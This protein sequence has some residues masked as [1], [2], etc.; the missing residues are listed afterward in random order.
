MNQ[1]AISPGYERK[2]RS[3]EHEGNAKQGRPQQKEEDNI[4]QQAELSRFRLFLSG[5]TKQFVRSIEG[6][7][8]G[9]YVAAED[10]SE[11]ERNNEDQQCRDKG[12]SKYPAADGCK[13]NQGR[14]KAQEEI[15]GCGRID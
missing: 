12:E 13:N 3:R 2:R 4:F 7:A 9:T 1:E 11:K 14:I 15:K 5:F 6:R 10:P 8:H